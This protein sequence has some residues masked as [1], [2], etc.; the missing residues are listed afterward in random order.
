VSIGSPHHRPNHKHKAELQKLTSEPSFRRMWARPIQIDTSKEIPDT[1]GYNVAGNIYFVDALFAAAVRAGRVV[2]PNMM[3]AQ[4][5]Q[6]VL[7]HERIEKC[8]LDADNDIDS[9][10]GAHEFATL[11]EHLFVIS[12]GAKPRLYEAALAPYIKQNETKPL[13]L[14][15][16]DLD[17]EPYVDRPDAEDNRAISEMVKLGVSDAG[18]VAKE[19]VRY[20][21]STT[22]DRC[23]GCKNWAAGKP[24]ELSA[25]ALISG[26]VRFDRWCSKFE[27]QER[28]TQ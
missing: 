13:R 11:S 6:A 25:C 28:K 15:P 23:V 22:G 8:L 4:I 19:S 10:E 17:A 5:M 14:P 3:P 20:G 7:M 9:Y 27:T 24:V 12:L 18:K 16:N 26:A 2:V 1:A 21:K